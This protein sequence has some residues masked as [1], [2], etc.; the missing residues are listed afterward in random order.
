PLPYPRPE[1]LVAFRSEQSAPDVEDFRAQV[2]GFQA[3][4]AYAAW[5]ADLLEGDEAVQIPAALGAGDLRRPFA[6]PA[7]PGR[8]LGLS[9]GRAG[10]DPVVVVSDESART[11]GTGAL[12][13]RTLTLSGRPFRVVGI[14]PPGFRLPLSEAQI[15]VPM[16]V[17]YPEAADARVAHFMTAVA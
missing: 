14:L 5:P 15:L 8:R 3:I 13:G 1:S 9:E 10:A 16:R 4:G 17:G 6:G 12:L 7:A 11:H 2:E